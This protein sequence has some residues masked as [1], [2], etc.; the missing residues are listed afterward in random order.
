MTEATDLA[1]RAGDRDPRVGLRAVAALRRLLEQLEAVQ[2]R[3]AR[4]QAV[5]AKASLTMAEVNL[6]KTIIASPIDGIVIA[7]SVDVG[8]TVAASL[9]APTLYSIA[10]DLSQMQVKTN[11]DESDLGNVREGQVVSFRVDA[12]PTRAFTGKVAQIR[13]DPVVAQNVVTYAAIISAPNPA[14]E[15]K[16]GMTANVTIEV[17]RRDNVLRVP[18]AAL[19]FRPTEAALTALGQDK[20]LA[21]PKAGA[22]GPAKPGTGV[23]Y[24]FDGQLHATPVTV[25]ATDGVNTEVS[26]DG[27]HEG[28]VLATRVADAAA[29]K[30]ASAASSPLMPQQG[31]PRRF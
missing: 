29:A 25:G 19:R 2:V 31:P 6:Q 18:S 30:P 5:Q 9:Q 20:I 16:P 13:L 10:A 21:P 22:S 24:M 17:G 11:V 23:V 1:E 4:A 12:Y 3:S 28:L 7:R 26:G 15:L 27:I 8:Q 14:L